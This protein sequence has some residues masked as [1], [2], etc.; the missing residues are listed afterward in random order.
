MDTEKH[1]QSAQGESE[2]RLE[3]GKAQAPV[4]KGND[5]QGNA[6]PCHE[7]INHSQQ[8][9]WWKDSQWWQVIV[10]GVLVPFGIYAVIVYSKQLDEMQKSTKAATRAANVANR[11]IEQ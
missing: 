6:C 8:L 7:K 4:P 9:A 2:Q 5:S 3:Q 1:E 11:S 10:A